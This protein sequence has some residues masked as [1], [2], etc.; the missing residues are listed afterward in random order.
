MRLEAAGSSL[1]PVLVPG[2]V[3]GSLSGL[4]LVFFNFCRGD[5]FNLLHPR[6]YFC[7]A[8]V[9]L[10]HLGF[11]L[12]RQPLPDSL[13][14]GCPTGLELA[15]VAMLLLEDGIEAWKKPFHS[16]RGSII[17][18]SALILSWALRGVWKLGDA[19]P[20]HILAIVL[21][22]PAM[23]WM[24]RRIKED[25]DKSEMV[26]A[27]LSGM[28]L[29][30]VYSFLALLALAQINP[31]VWRGFTKF[32]A[33]GWDSVTGTVAVANVCTLG[34]VVIVNSSYVC[35]P[36][37]AARTAAG[38]L[39]L[40][41]FAQGFS[42]Y[43]W[44]LL[45]GVV[46]LFGGVSA[47]NRKVLHQALVDGTF[48]KLPSYLTGTQ[49][50]W[51][52]MRIGFC[53]LSWKLSVSSIK[54]IVNLFA[55]QE[56]KFVG[57]EIPLFD[58]GDKV[59]LGI[60]AYYSPGRDTGAWNGFASGVQG[61][62]T[63]DTHHKLVIEDDKSGDRIG[64]F[65]CEVGHIDVNHPAGL[66]DIQRNLTSGSNSWS[67]FS[68]GEA[69]GLLAHV[70]CFFPHIQ[71]TPLA[72][73]VNLQAWRTPEDAEKWSS[74]SASHSKMTADR[75][76]GRMGTFGNITAPLKPVGKIRYQDRCSRCARI[77]ESPELG[78]VP[79]TRC[80]ACK[81]RTFGYPLI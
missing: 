2:L 16:R 78:S 52:Q 40:G 42:G 34:L 69:E 21:V 60:A 58:L 23:S 24:V 6:G 76:N 30:G 45:F 71:G 59:D 35:S 17:S 9:M 67:E 22:A 38:T 56:I 51:D 33:M 5:C 68:R 29:A 47:R 65:V 20:G 13:P 7:G 14:Q 57:L 73:E 39:L 19:A 1:L 3:L 31:E 32:Q 10:L 15:A 66:T 50:L 11:T 46:G 36:A 49:A 8:A 26:N 72:K 61:K 48:E 55:P 81:A 77:Q 43:R 64:H 27:I 79:P 28:Q 41:T 18:I 63:V 75:S 80:G 53:Q 12:A 74:R 25:G 62:A 70:T 37:W 54:F 44:L 4:S